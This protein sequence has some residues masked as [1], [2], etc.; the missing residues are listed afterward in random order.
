MMLTVL[1]LIALPDFT[2]LFVVNTPM[3]DGMPDEGGGGL[4]PPVVDHGPPQAGGGVLVGTGAP[5][6]NP[7]IADDAVPSEKIFTFAH[8][9]SHQVTTPPLPALVSPTTNVPP[10]GKANTIAVALAEEGR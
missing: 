6:A 2:A 9:L 3:N 10:G 7:F 4:V 1:P 5:G 8:E